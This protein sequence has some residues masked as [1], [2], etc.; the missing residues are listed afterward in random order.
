MSLFETELGKFDWERME[1]GC[2]ESAAH[3]PGRIRE[4]AG[5]GE[6]YGGE[7]FT[8]PLHD[9]VMTPA[10]GLLPVSAAFIPI[11]YAALAG[12][13]SEPA[14][15]EMLGWILRIVGPAID[16]DDDVST[17]CVEAARQGLPLLYSE[18][19]QGPSEAG[20]A[21]AFETLLLIEEDLDRLRAVQAEARER[22]PWDL[23]SEEI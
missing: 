1:C 21:Y 8:T 16:S 17:A 19:A 6:A 5:V 2:G 23:R 7:A 15:R 4:L 18:V 9:H 22:L 11:A 10:D 14:R 13:L 3:L 12:P 20:A